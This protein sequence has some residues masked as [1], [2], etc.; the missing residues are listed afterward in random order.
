MKTLET[1]RL[2]LRSW[3]EEDVYDLYEYAKNP[4]IGPMAG[5][6]PHESLNKSK[7][8]IHH[9]IEADDSWAIVLKEAG[10]VI[11]SIGLHED[12]Q[13]RISKDKTRRL[14]YVLSEDY[15]GQGIMPEAVKKV[16]SFAFEEL[17]IEV[18]A[19]NH[20]SNNKQSRRVI[21]KVGF[22]YEGTIRKAIQLFDG[23][24]VDNVCYSLLKEEYFNL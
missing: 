21:E 17:K 15:W 12:S 6:R 23:T 8:I 19:V 20:Y 14:G 5:W 1:D 16:I 11:G 9:F 18:L 4:K 22:H 2:L 10:K 7:E 24:I 13:R 3:Q